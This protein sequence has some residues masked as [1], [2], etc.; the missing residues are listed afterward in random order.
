MECDKCKVKSNMK[1]HLLAICF[2]LT[3]VNS[4]TGSIPQHHMEIKGQEII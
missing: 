1:N 3:S 2:N 4:D